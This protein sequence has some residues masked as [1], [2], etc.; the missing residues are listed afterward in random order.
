MDQSSIQIRC[1]WTSPQ[2]RSGVRGPV[3]NPDQVCVDQSSIQIRC[4]WTSPQSR[5]G[6]RGLVLNPDQLRSA[7]R[8]VQESL[9]WVHTAHSNDHSPLQTRGCPSR[10]HR[11]LVCQRQ[12]HVTFTIGVTSRHHG[13]GHAAPVQCRHHAGSVGRLSQND[14]VPVLKVSWC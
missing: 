8:H 4:A 9:V 2:S 10:R 12:C 14:D 7:A 1:A 5:S 13:H 11:H 3:F 6:V